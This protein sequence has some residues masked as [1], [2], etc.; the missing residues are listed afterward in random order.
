M[1]EAWPARAVL[2]G[3]AAARMGDVSD[4]VEDATIKT[5]IHGYDD[6]HWNRASVIYVEFGAGEGRG[7]GTALVVQR[8]VVVLRLNRLA[9]HV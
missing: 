8:T 5:A 1:Q 4:D 6:R 2:P 9:V 7:R 3:T